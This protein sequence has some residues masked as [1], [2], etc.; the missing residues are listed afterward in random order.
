MTSSIDEARSVDVAPVVLVVEDNPVERAL[1]TRILNVAD[2]SVIAVECGQAALDH[3][4]SDDPDLILLDALLPDIVGFDVCRELRKHP[5]LR[6]IPIIMLTGLDDVASID[7]AYDAGATDFITKPINHALLVHRVRYLLRTSLMF[8]ELR[9][10]KKSLASAQRIA[11]LGHWEF[12]IDR[13]RVRFSEEFCQL[14]RIDAQQCGNSFQ[15]LLDVCHAED[16]AQ[17]EQ[18]IFGAIRN[19]GGDRVEHRV[20]YSDGSERVMEMHLAVIPDEDDTRH[21]LGISMD[22]TARKE[23]EREVLR[24]AYFD[25]LTGLPNRSL[26]ELILDQEIP[27]A[28][29]AGQA[30]AA[31]CIDL[32]LFSR[33]NNA[34][35]HSAGDAVLRQIAHR[36]GRLINAPAP[37]FLLERLSLSMDLNGSWRNGLAA[38]LGGD[39]FALLLSGD[40]LRQAALDLAQSVRQLFHQAFLYRGQEMFVTASIGFSCSDSATVAAEMLLQQADMALREAKAEARSDIREYHRGLVAQVST[41]MSIQSDLR[42][43]L[44]SGEFMVF[45]QPKIA[46]RNNVVTGFEALIRWRH[47]VRGNI[48]PI[49]FIHVAEETGQIVDIGRWVL[50]T[51]CYQFRLWLERKLVSGRIAVNISARQFREDNLAAMVLTALA[52]AG[53]PPRHLELEIT[54]GVLMSDPHA[55]DVIAELRSHGI[56]IALDDFGTGYSSLSYLTRFP[57]DTLKIDRC[58]VSEINYESEQ[59]AI[60]TAVTSL[61]HRLNLKVVAEGVETDSELQVIT[62]LSCDEVQGNLFCQPLAAADIERWLEQYS[63]EK[64]SSRSAS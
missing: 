4:L 59:A 7:R 19:S 6:F 50:Q 64:S 27:R 40:H 24:L 56:S 28:H 55:A 44:R 20:C 9:L 38:R 13:P 26:L 60:V 49:E 5:R 36:L 52:Q 8:E 1:I 34:M 3:A 14:Y 47:P 23:T 18:S 2:L 17:V 51:A 63:G 41:Q 54:E 29:L 43:A 10:G 61:S 62:D 16:R 46:L 57:I 33:V 15:C 30:V 37:Q 25:R 58:F 53:L 48:S 42:K 31:I 12:N 45:Y 21:L 32:D 22:I 39:T 35:G 11:K